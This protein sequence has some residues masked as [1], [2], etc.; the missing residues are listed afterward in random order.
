LEEN[1]LNIELLVGLDEC[2]NL[3][4]EKVKYFTELRNKEVNTKNELKR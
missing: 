1:D 3:N 4:T 2:S